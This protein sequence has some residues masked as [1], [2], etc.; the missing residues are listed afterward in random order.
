MHMIHVQKIIHIIHSRKMILN[1]VDNS[2]KQK[3]FE[4]LNMKG[5]IIPMYNNQFSKRIVFKLLKGFD[6]KKR[7][8]LFS[9]INNYVKE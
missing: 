6:T 1:N 4:H 3:V 5:F 2:V 8:I 9:Y 7:K